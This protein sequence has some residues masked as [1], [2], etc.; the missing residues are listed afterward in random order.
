MLSVVTPVDRAK[1]LHGVTTMVVGPHGIGK[2][3]LTRKLDVESTLVADIE[4][5]TLSIKDLG[6]DIVR[7]QSW[8]EC[9]DLV[10]RLGGVDPAAPVN[11]LYSA[12]HLQRA[13]GLLDEARK[14]H[15]VII[16][17]VSAVSRLAM[18]WAELQPE[19]Y[20][21]RTG[22]KDVRG[23][24]GLLAREMV[25][26]IERIQHLRDRN[27]VL[28]CVLELRANDAGFSEWRPQIEG[29]KAVREAL[30]IVDEVITY[31]W[32]D[33]G[34]GPKRA[35]ITT[36]PN[37]WGY[38]AKDRSGKLEQIEEPNL[39]KLLSKLNGNTNQTTGE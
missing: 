3:S 38:P 13:G 39:A 33:W 2:T 9:C 4:A 37:Q 32:I 11:G 22:K 28:N 17:S 19:A 20:S 31:Q 36:S 7:P 35:F 23:A 15:T 1:E 34:E 29:A 14:Y 30:A 8:P 16:D 26:W 6:V 18:Q 21:D 25:R 12:E 24:Y 5:G 10:V 27:V